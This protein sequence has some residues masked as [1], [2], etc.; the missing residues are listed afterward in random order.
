MLVV[1]LVSLN[2]A[3]VLIRS[4]GAGL[5]V[6]TPKAATASPIAP[7]SDVTNA[8]DDFR[9]EPV[10]TLALPPTA[11]RYVAPIIAPDTE[12]QLLG[13][14]PGSSF[15]LSDTLSFYWQWPLPLEEDQSLAAYLLVEDQELLVGR[16][17]EPNVG[18]TYWLQLLASDFVDDS[19]LVQ[20]QVRLESIYGQQWL[21]ASEIR[22]LALQATTQLMP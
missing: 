14:P 6:Q 19:G 10:A 16:L 5:P 15:T 7:A 17:V 22:P 13:P 12:I 11:T 8:S 20:W 9:E 3:P 21:A 18:T 4:S 1:C 2:L